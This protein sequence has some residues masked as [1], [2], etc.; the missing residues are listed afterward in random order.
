M[1]WCDSQASGELAASALGHGPKQTF[2]K[3]AHMGRSADGDNGVRDPHA[4]PLLPTDDS[5]HWLGLLQMKC[6]I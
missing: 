1:T 5:P 3:V 6:L 4:S 2:Q